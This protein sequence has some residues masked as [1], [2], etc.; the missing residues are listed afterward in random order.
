MAKH[1]TI[2]VV[3]KDENASRIMRT[4]LQKF[5]YDVIIAHSEQQ[6]FDYMTFQHPDLII[7]GVLFPEGPTGYEFCRKIRTD[8]RTQDIPFIFLTSKSKI[9]DRIEGLK[10]GADDY[11]IK[12]FDMDELHARIQM[13]FKRL[14]RA[15]RLAATSRTTTKGSLAQMSLVDIIGIF[16]MTKKTGVLALTFDQHKFGSVYLKDGNVVHAALQDLVGEEAFYHLLK[17]KDSGNFEFTPGVTS[18]EHTIQMRGS[19]LIMEGLRRLDESTRD[20]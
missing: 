16:E 2:L 4:R 6:A 10:A 8:T 7:S 18:P 12:P 20:S 11:I 3:N 14:E 17:W 13:I 9:D 19:E 1:Y 5:G 15:Q